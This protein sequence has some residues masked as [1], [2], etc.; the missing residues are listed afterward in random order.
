ALGRTTNVKGVKGAGAGWWRTPLGGNGGMHFYLWWAPAGAPPV[1]HLPLEKDQILVRMVRHHDDT[2]EA[3]EAGTPAD[4]LA[5]RPAA[6]NEGDLGGDPLTPEQ[7][8]VLRA[9]G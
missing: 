5:Q 1:R 9:T 3:L 8:E 2:E 7:R 4:W 6:L